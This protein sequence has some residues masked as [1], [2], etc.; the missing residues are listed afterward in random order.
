M[1]THSSI[2]AQKIQQTEEPGRLQSTGSQRVGHDF[3]MKQQCAW[4]LNCSV[5]SNSLWPMDC[6]PP[7]SSI[8]GPL[9]AKNTGGGCH[10]F[11]P[12]DLPDPGIEPMSLAS[13]VL[14]GRLF[15]TKPPGKPKQQQQKFLLEY[16]CF[17]ILCQ[18]LLSPFSKQIDQASG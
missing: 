16:S 10:F 13:P 6:N 5:V 14:A 3:T 18:F 1:P 2:F 4:V 12:G 15:T 7:G 11:L 8:H 17:T 9:Q